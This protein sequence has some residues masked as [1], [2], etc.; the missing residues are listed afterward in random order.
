MKKTLATMLALIMALT[1]VPAIATGDD[2]TGNQMLR[3]GCIIWLSDAGA[4]AINEGIASNEEVMLYLNCD[5][6]ETII[7]PVGK[8]VKL[9]LNNHN[10]SVTTGDAIV[11]KG[12]LTIEGSGTV[13]TS[14]T[15]SAAIANFPGATA[16]IN[17]GTYVS[18]KWYVIKNLGKMTIDGSVTVKKPEGSTDTSSLITNGWYGT[19]DTVAKE[20]V[21]AKADSA[22]LHI[23]SGS[24]EG[25]SGSASCSVVKNDDYGTL[26]IEG[27]TFDSTNNSNQSSATTILN[28]NV[29]SIT[30]GKFIG[31]YPISNGAY[32]SEADR[33]YIIITGGEF[34]GKNRLIGLGQGG[35]GKGFLKILGGSFTAPE[36]GGPFEAAGG[37]DIEIVGGTFSCSIPEG[38]V[39]TGYK[40]NG[41][42][43]TDGTTKYEIEEIKIAGL[44]GDGS[45][46]LVSEEAKIEDVAETRMMVK[47]SDGSSLNINYDESGEENYVLSVE[48]ADNKSENLIKEAV[49]RHEIGEK[50]LSEAIIN[51]VKQN[52]ETLELTEEGNIKVKQGSDGQSGDSGEQEV[53]ITPIKV[54]K[55][56]VTTG[57]VTE[58]NGKKTVEVHIN[59]IYELKFEVKVGNVKI[60]SCSDGIVGIYNL[61]VNEPTE[62]KMTLPDGFVNDA[63]SAYRTE[64]EQNSGVKV[65]CIKHTKYINEKP[66][67][68]YYTGNATLNNENEYELTFTSEHGF[69]PF[70]ISTAKYPTIAQNK[71]VGYE[72]LQNAIDDAKDKD[73]ITLT[74]ELTENDLTASRKGDKNRTINFENETGK[75]VVLKIDGV[76][77]KISAGA[78]LALKSESNSTHEIP[79]TPSTPTTPIV[80]PSYTPSYSGSS[81]SSGNTYSWYFN[82]TPTPTPVL[83]AP[84]VA[85]PKTGDMTIWQSIL[86]FFGLI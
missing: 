8:K 12:T 33:G 68:Y 22:E 65:V 48:I 27:G 43:E 75:D 14:A 2:V 58:V 1:M 30:G 39:P 41:K 4:A 18:D 17:G 23:K 54:P 45:E 67:N 85:L 57:V 81:S 9:D 35:N 37:Y 63:G 84:A 13:S 83:V 20:Q 21:G 24:F 52:S 32:T 11:N 80:I 26:Y 49:K 6:T 61:E 10:I 47:Q 55:L 34:E 70:E 16:N 15:N 25:K 56:S 79:V 46:G 62:V 86:S 73:T 51:L 38:Y 74:A 28:W 42:A 36:I 19:T 69:S 3:V 60:E 66:V 78:M 71:T 72:T 53:T 76:E 77:L 7:V 31:Q 5:V 40:V 64:S 44:G 50:E 82:P 59:P 29:T